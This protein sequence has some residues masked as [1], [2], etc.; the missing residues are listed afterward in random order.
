MALD[1]YRSAGYQLGITALYVL[2]CPAL[3]ANSKRDAALDLIE[4]GLTMTNHN[5]ERIFEAEL[6]RLKANALLIC[7]RLDTDP[8]VQALLEQSLALAKSQQAKA[9]EL[10]AAK[11]L[12]ALWVSQGKRTEARGLLDPIYASFT[13]GFE[14]RDLIEAKALLAQLQ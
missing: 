10:R 4:Q 9:L 7:G 5:S 3:L 11:S 13:E 2:L 12:A 1:E 6:Y 8:E 14:T